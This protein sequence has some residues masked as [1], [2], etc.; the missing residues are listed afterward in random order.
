MNLTL[1]LGGLVSSASKRVANP[2]V[3]P[4][5]DGPLFL[6]LLQK[7]SLPVEHTTVPTVPD[8]KTRSGACKNVGFVKLAS[9]K[10]S[11]F[12]DARTSI[13]EDLEIFSS[14]KE[15][16]F[17]VPGLGPVSRKQE[18]QFGGLYAFLRGTTLDKHLGEGTLLDPL[19]V[20]LVELETPTKSTP[21][22]LST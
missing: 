14:D 3:E 21:P 1:A 16:K 22:H 5:E 20:F 6:K 8:C 11:T 4:A 15:W 2:I 13:L 7:L 19:K 9:R 10:L 12:A 18:T 17:F